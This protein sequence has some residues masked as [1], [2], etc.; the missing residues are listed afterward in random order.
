MQITANHSQVSIATPV[1][2][3]ARHSR[4]PKRKSAYSNSKLR[5]CTCTWR[6]RIVRRRVW[7]TSDCIACIFRWKVSLAVTFANGRSH[8][9]QL[10]HASARHCTD[11][12]RTSRW[13]P[14]V[15]C[16]F[17]YMILMRFGVFYCWNLRR[18][19]FRYEQF[20]CCLMNGWNLVPYTDIAESLIR[21]RWI[22]SLSAVFFSV[23]HFQ[24][25]LKTKTTVFHCQIKLFDKSKRQI[26]DRIIFHDGSRNFCNNAHGCN[27]VLLQ[28]AWPF[29]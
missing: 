11:N 21:R 27:R 16:E 15:I 13:L 28:A 14:D 9:L 19:R 18:W 3:Y 20:V 24:V 2:N 23:I 17:Y 29:F 6:T 5:T 12:S 7:H 25:K 1:C 22:F 26:C 10:G 4:A 8:Q